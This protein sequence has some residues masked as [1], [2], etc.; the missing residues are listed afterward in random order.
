MERIIKAVV[1]WNKQEVGFDKKFLELQDIT[2]LIV[3]DRGD[4]IILRTKIKKE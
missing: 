1:N 3:E 2:E 4:T